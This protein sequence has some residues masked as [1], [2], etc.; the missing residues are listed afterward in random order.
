MDFSSIIP[1]NLLREGAMLNGCFC[2]DR[3]EMRERE[4]L[5]MRYLQLAH[6][7]Q[8]VAQPPSLSRV[9]AGAE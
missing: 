3:R 7:L 8:L 4:R 9:I 2:P 6:R 1:S 5:V